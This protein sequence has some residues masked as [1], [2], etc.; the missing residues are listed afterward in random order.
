[1]KLWVLLLPLAS[2]SYHVMCVIVGMSH[3]RTCRQAACR[4]ELADII[5]LC[6]S[7]Y[8]FTHEERVRPEG[9]LWEVNLPYQ[10]VSLPGVWFFSSCLLS[11][12]LVLK[13]P[14]HKTSIRF[15]LSMNLWWCCT[16]A[17]TM[18]MKRWQAISKD[19]RI[20]RLQVMKDT[21]WYLGPLC[22]MI[23]W[24][25]L[26]NLSSYF[27]RHKTNNLMK[28]RCVICSFGIMIQQ[29]NS[30]SWT[31]RN[32]STTLSFCLSFIIRHFITMRS[33]WIYCKEVIKAHRRRHPWD[34]SPL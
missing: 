6:W 30:K 24:W 22:Y 13:N 8:M 11:P 1:M 7:I 31:S 14:S 10:W 28:D 3:L 12:M 23:G 34:F 17:H 18:E 5:K 29:N 21:V 32:M 19:Q 9:R 16:H 25:L 26:H 2:T 4:Y 15:G 20:E 27:I 33:W